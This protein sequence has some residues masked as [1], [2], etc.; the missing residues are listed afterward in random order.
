[1]VIFD[2]SDWHRRLYKGIAWVRDAV[3]RC[4]AKTSIR[5]GQAI[6]FIG[7]WCAPRWP[8][9]RAFVWARKVPLGLIFLVASAGLFHQVYTTFFVDRLAGTHITGAGLSA[10]SPE[11]AKQRFRKPYGVTIISASATK[12]YEDFRRI[13]YRLE[14]VR[15]GGGMVPRVFVKAMPQDIRAVNS[16][17]TRKAVFIKTLL[18]LVLH[19]NEELKSI[20]ARVK[21]LAG[22]GDKGRALAPGDAAWL[23]AQYKRFRVANGDVAALLLRVDVIPP[24]LALAQGAEESGWGTSRFAIEGQALFGQRTFRQG[25]GLVPANRAE[26]SRFKVK[27]FDRLLD[28]VRSY[29]QNLNTHPAYGGF[30]FLRAQLRAGANGA[31]GID[32]FRLV[33]GL[34]NYSERGSQYVESIKRIMRV[35]NLKGLDNARLSQSL[36][37]AEKLAPA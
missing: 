4:V 19:A 30:R 27:T 10:I 7:A 34:I 1:M 5:L 23:D 31:D 18:P 3:V 25:R 32:S 36:A 28:A 24:S 15:K 35:N 20:R 33:E 16:V 8:A 22:R 6:R 9:F 26:G 13:G 29:A 2:I 12:L 17:A 11:E 21:A 14:D 37:G